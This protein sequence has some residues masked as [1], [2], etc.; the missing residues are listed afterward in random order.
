[1][2]G[3]RDHWGHSRHGPRMGLG[4]RC[5]GAG[6]AVLTPGPGLG[7]AGKSARVAT[8]PRLAG[9]GESIAIPV[10]IVAI[11]TSRGVTHHHHHTHIHARH[12]L[13]ATLT[14][15]QFALG[16]LAD[17]IIAVVV[18]T[19]EAARVGDGSQQH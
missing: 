14:Q 17:P 19:G 8:G 12:T 5:A 7:D 13:L 1:V 9:A 3:G 4:G 11:P 2:H 16:P 6:R 15:L 18:V 10:P